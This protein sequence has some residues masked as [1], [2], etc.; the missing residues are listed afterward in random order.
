VIDDALSIRVERAAEQWANGEP[1]DHRA[2]AADETASLAREVIRAA[3]DEDELWDRWEGGFEIEWLADAPLALADVGR[4]DEALALWA[5][6]AGRFPELDDFEA[7]RALLLAGAGRLDEARA[8]VDAIV[9]DAKDDPSTLARVVNIMAMYDPALAERTAR[10][11]VTESADPLDVVAGGEV[12]AELL[13]ARG[14]EEAAAA[15]EARV[16]T[17]LTMADAWDIDEAP[18]GTVV[19]DG[20]KIGRNDPCPCGSGKK[21]KKCHGR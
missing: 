7:M 1:G 21:Y 12:L 20:P 6:L 16:E 3:R 11:L 4:F 15:V 9:G 8:A 19:R 17:A 18:T 5:E 10:M 14:D 2:D 13:H